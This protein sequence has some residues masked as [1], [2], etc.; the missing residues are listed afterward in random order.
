M[1]LFTEMKNSRYFTHIIN[2]LFIVVLALYPMRHVNIGLDLW[3]TGYNYSN[4]EYMGPGSMDSMWL[5]STY[6][7]TALGHLFTLLPFGKT[8]I[9]MNVYTALLPAGTAIISFL[10]CTR[11]LEMD[12][13]L[14]FVGEMVSLS[15]CWCPTS[16]IYNFLT[17]LFMHLALIFMYIGMSEDK[18]PFMAASGALIGL[19]V[20]VRFSNLPEIVFV[21]AIWAYGVVCV[22]RKKKEIKPAVPAELKKAAVRTLIFFAGYIAAIALVLG[23]I[24]IRYGIDEY[25]SGIKRLFDIPKLS[26][27]YSSKEMLAS[28]IFGYLRNTKW[29]LALM[30]FAGVSGLFAFLAG[31]AGAKGKKA[32]AGILWVLCLLTAV[33]SIAFLFLTG[34][35]SV[36]ATDGAS[37]EIPGTVLTYLMMLFAAYVIFSG[38]K[39]FSEADKLLAGLVILLILVTPIGSNNG[40]VLTFNNLFIAMPWFI[41]TCLKAFGKPVLAAA[42]SVIA[43]FC[44]V[45]FVRFAIFGANYVFVDAQ[46]AV[47]T[48]HT[49]D[50]PATLKGVR[51][52]E[53]RAAAVSG[54]YEYVSDKNLYGNSEIITYGFIP[55]LS[56]YLQMPPAFN[57]WPDLESYSEDVMR[58]DVGE[59][60][61]IANDGNG[62]LPLIVVSSGYSDYM[63]Q[64][65][66]TGNGKLDAIK[67]LLWAGGYSSEYKNDMFE[68]FYP[69]V[70]GK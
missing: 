61:Q 22:L 32:P 40:I 63:A 57:S 62:E 9:G 3:D 25:I 26:Y 14:T 42:G 15:L 17:Y 11:R 58:K 24:G 2:A 50:A 39:E 70:K 33:L 16:L 44:A 41:C 69:G 43:A 35:F 34:F 66:M 19:N 56:F 60:I 31:K 28:V 36:R 47:N 38:F 49:I 48:D 45:C 8:L 59:Y 52:S 18:P 23:F 30:A 7:S 46:P 53:E 29:V 37:L 64:A 6:L 68:A 20:F 27:H 21:I 13:V 5:F 1:K 54:L 4:F 10:F 51:M 67:E 12:P 65:E 55:S